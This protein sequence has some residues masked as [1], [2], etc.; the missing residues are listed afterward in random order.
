[1]NIHHRRTHPDA[2]NLRLERPLI[3]ARVMADVR[4]GTAH[5]KADQLVKAGDLCSFNHPD[6][7]T[8]WA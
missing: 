3:S 8:R 7:A 2:G 6:D 5:V 4:A 1:M